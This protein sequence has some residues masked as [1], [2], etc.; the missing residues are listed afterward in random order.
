[1]NISQEPFGK[2]R[3]GAPVELYTLSNDQGVIIKI[4]TYGGVI[5]HLLTPDRTGAPGDI[6]LGYDTLDEYLAFSPYFGAITGRFANRIANARFSLQGKEYTLAQN[7]GM[8][9]LH[10][11][12]RGFDKVVWQARSFR[13]PTAVGVALTYLSPD[14]EEGYPGNLSTTV[15]YSLSNR[16]ALKID[17]FAVTDAPTV[18]NLTNHAY[19]NLACQG[20]ILNHVMMLK[21][22][23]FTPTDA[24][25]IPTGE[26]RS[27]AG[28]PMDFRTPTPIGARIEADYEPLKF[29]LGY[30]HNWVV[31]GRPGDLRLAAVV[32]EPTS[33][34]KMEV[35]TTQPG[36]QLYTGNVLD[37]RARGKGRIFGRR[38]GFCLET[39]HFPDGPNQPGFPTTTLKPGQVYNEV[40]VF[41]FSVD[42]ID[43]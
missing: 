20:D 10:G 39:Q 19:F 11:G 3:E 36:I 28:T 5:T 1:M 30:D 4:A 9:H 15:T 6:T 34:R 31:K 25:Q 26:I 24:G 23:A 13:T 35:H 38:T 37:G 17:Y 29:G 7:N 40:T 33:G 18:L 41:R 32:T 12:L 2:T 27:V 42:S 22:D 21:A 8:N 43:G 16:N 14:G